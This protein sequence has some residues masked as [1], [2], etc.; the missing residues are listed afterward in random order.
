VAGAPAKRVVVLPMEG[1]LNP[2]RAFVSGVAPS[3]LPMEGVLNPNN[4][5]RH[6]LL[7]K[8]SHEIL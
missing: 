2:V 4:C 1:V 7:E 3:A 5:G 6:Q 8:L